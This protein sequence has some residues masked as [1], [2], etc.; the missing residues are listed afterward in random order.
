[1]KELG[2]ELKD[3][4]GFATTQGRITI[5]TNQTSQSFQ[6]LNRQPKSAHGETRGSSRY[7]AVDGLVR[8]QWRRG[9]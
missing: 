1:M 6:G 7:V 5:L 2:E 8:H 9:L 4:K 3:M